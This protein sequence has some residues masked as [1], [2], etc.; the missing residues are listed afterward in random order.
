MTYQEEMAKFDTAKMCG[1]ATERGYNQ[2]SA[3][4][5]PFYALDPRADEIEI[6]V[7]AAHLSRICRFV[8]GLRPE[9]EI[10]SVAQ[11][12]CLVSDHL[13]PDLALEGLLHDA[14]EA[15]LGDMPKPIKMNLRILSGADFWSQLEH[16]VERIVRRKFGL[17]ERMTPAVKQQDFIAVATEHRDLQVNTGK[18]DWGVQ[19]MPTPWPERI[20]PWGVFRARDEFMRRFLA[21]YRHNGD[22]HQ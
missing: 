12:C 1:L 18:V 16:G 14:H 19:H 21:L 15:W 4:G 9:V 5:Q 20:E 7:I 2:C 8:G 10:Y 22:C 17:P 3:N 13:L 11:H 6:E